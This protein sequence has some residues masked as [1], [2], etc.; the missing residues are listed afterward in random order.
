MFLHHTGQNMTWSI[1]M[2]IILGIAGQV[3]TN[4]VFDIYKTRI[5]VMDG[6]KAVFPCRLK[7]PSIEDVFLKRVD[8]PE[9]RE[10]LN[11]TYD[12]REGVIIERVQL[13]DNGKYYCEANKNGMKFK[14]LDFRLVVMPVQNEL[15]KTR[16]LLE[17]YVRIVGERFEVSCIAENI[18]FDMEVIWYHKANSTV[19]I[20]DYATMNKVYTK[21]VTLSIDSVTLGDT[22]NFTC[23]ATNQIGTSKLMT[24]LQVV[25][26][27]YIRM[28]ANESTINVKEGEDV[29]LSVS[30]DAY[31]ELL[32]H[33]WK[34]AKKENMEPSTIITKGIN[35]YAST[36]TLQRIKPEE[37]GQYTFSAT[38]VNNSPSNS[39]SSITFNVFVHY[40]KNVE[41]HTMNSSGMYYCTANGFPA[42]DIKWYSCQNSWCNGSKEL[43]DGSESYQT[44]DSTKDIFGSIEMESYINADKMSGHLILECSA[45]NDAG[46]EYDHIV[47][48]PPPEETL[49]PFLIAAVGLTT[50]ML[51]I[52]IVLIYKYKQKPK[53]E[54]RW[55]IIQVGEGNEYTFID[56]SQL[57]YNEKLEFPRSQLHLGKTLGAGAFGKVVAATAYGLG[58]EDANTKVAVKMLKPTAHSDEKEALMSE[59][60]IMSHL[61]Q[62]ENIVNLLG[63]CTYGGPILVITEYCCH[64]DLLN[65]LRKKADCVIAYPIKEL[66][67]DCI[68]D[69][70]NIR[71]NKKYTRSDS[72]FGSQHSDGYQEM[73]SAFINMK[74]HEK[75]YGD[76]K[77]E[78]DVEP[79]NLDDLLKFSNDVAQ[80]MAFL[81]SKNCIH[82]DLAARNILVSNGRV[83]KICDFGLARDIMND[84]NYVVKGN[85][86]LPVK[87]MAPESI[88]ECVYTVQSDVW[89]YG[90]LLWE[91][92]SL[93]KGPYPSMAVDSKF[94]KLIKDGYQMSRPDFAPPQMY[95]IMQSCWKLEPTR[96]PTFE[97]IGKLIKEQLRDLSLSQ[98]YENIT[99]L[100]EA[101]EEQMDEVSECFSESCSQGPNAEL[102]PRSNNY[103]FC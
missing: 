72:G 35:R 39:S 96:R 59:L 93:G 79:L 73:K 31:P 87:W 44:S 40:L 71:A 50:A 89:S 30:F 29:N 42:P 65:F 91:I 43:I 58:K 33:E 103:Q 81:S 10:G 86:R 62:H 77:T 36:Y 63:A 101:K 41:L 97:Q 99:Y 18:D 55:K 5:V 74:R 82:R 95:D 22:G 3:D 25:G 78:E 60:K 84:T 26:E 56:P 67:Q 85:A 32:K 11:V 54:V 49:K 92:F 37:A 45:S 75:N 69:Y 8:S 98:D 64:G 90:I 51:L 88:F 9:L 61:G 66:L 16:P 76:N 27:P 2:V 12:K 28:Y 48:V 47:Q 100:T 46:Q 68:G 83:A 24:H 70:K 52:I 1:L 102:L 34:S 6:A 38:N 15:P 19:R 17:D 21:T 94:Y 57:P 14:S 80:G 4:D 20:A 53:F 7:D 23:E 13:I